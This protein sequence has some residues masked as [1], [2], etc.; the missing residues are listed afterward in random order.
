MRAKDAKEMFGQRMREAQ[1]RSGL[2]NRQVAEQMAES[3]PG[4]PEWYSEIET[5]TR[6]LRRWKAGD[7]T[8]NAASA[9]QFAGIVG[10]SAT[11]FSTGVNDSILEPLM[12][13]IDSLVDKRVE[14]HVDRLRELTKEMGFRADEHP[15]DALAAAAGYCAGRALVA[16]AELLGG[17]VAAAKRHLQHAID[18]L[19]P[20]V[21]AAEAVA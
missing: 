10:C 3:T 14:E 6:N 1:G 20:A 15:L 2:R 13:A 21:A 17:D 8:P 5:L 18:R 12:R 4:S 7:A 11:Y 9:L 16:R 19:E